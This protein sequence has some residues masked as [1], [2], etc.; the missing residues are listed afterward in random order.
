MR[1]R[2]E[3]MLLKKRF[4]IILSLLVLSLLA[5]QP[6]VALTPKQIPSPGTYSGILSY[7]ANPISVFGVSF[8]DYTVYE[9]Q[10]YKDE[11]VRVILE[12]PSG[13]DFDL[14]VECIH[15]SEDP[16]PEHEDHYW[17]SGEA[18]IDQVEFTAPHDG[19]YYV[20]IY[21]YYGSG[22]YT[23][24]IEIPGRPALIFGMEPMMFYAI[25][26]IVA[27]IIVGGVIFSIRR[28][29]PKAHPAPASSFT[30]SP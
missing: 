16:L 23:L 29:K 30:P 10:L 12:S 3:G 8:G 20:G 27:V 22:Y 4:S 14:S 15:Q 9:I 25:V 24:T 18:E 28:R 11:I 5:I 26:S 2:I 1:L 6:T 13:A 21:A 17:L 7:G 19:E